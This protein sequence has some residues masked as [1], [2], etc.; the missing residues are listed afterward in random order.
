MNYVVVTLLSALLAGLV[1]FVYRWR[2]G[3]PAHATIKHFIAL[4]ALLIF[5]A[6]WSIAALRLF[7]VNMAFLLAAGLGAIIPNIIWLQRRR[8]VLA[9]HGHGNHV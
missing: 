3:L 4:F 1:H 7:P 6:L 5:F 8:R 2:F 9:P